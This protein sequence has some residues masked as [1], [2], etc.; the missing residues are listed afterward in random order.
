MRDVQIAESAPDG[1]RWK[2]RGRIPTRGR[3]SRALPKISTGIRHLGGYDGAL[4]GLS[5][6]QV[7]EADRQLQAE[8]RSGIRSVIARRLRVTRATLYTLAQ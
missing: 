2:D 6:G 1:E 8:L 5:I 7:T 4:T 3:E